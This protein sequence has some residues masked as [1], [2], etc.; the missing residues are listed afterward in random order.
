LIRVSNDGRPFSKEDVYSICKVGWSSKTPKDY[1]GYLG[2][3]VKA[4]FL[5]SE[6]PEIYSG[7]Y[8]FK[9]DK[10][11]WPDPE[12]I[13][14]Q[15]V[16]IWIDKPNVQS[17]E[18]YKTIF[19]IPLKNPNLTEKI[20]EEVKPEHLSNRILLFLRNIKK[21][22]IVDHHQ[23]FKRKIVK[24][25]FSKSSDYEIYEIQEYENGS[26]KSDNRWLIFRSICNVPKEVKEDY[27]TKEW[28]RENV[29]KREVLVAFKLDEEGNLVREE[30][31]TAHV[32][33]FSFL[34]LKEVPS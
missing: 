30:K 22:E 4:V 31:G 13:P 3:G 23:N 10:S 27:I 15:V 25:V 33:V 1:I 29:E 8:Q 7:D 21:I 14:W 9:F 32:G 12:R 5:I 34:P 28:E 26:P 6:C 24:S 19:N 16:P 20:R 18:E 2:V 17:S 11:A